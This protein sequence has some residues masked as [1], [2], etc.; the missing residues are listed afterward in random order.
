MV[1]LEGSSEIRDSRVVGPVQCP[2]HGIKDGYGDQQVACSPIDANTH[3]GLDVPIVVEY[4]FLSEQV[5]RRERGETIL[6]GHLVDRSA[7]S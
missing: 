6:N 3:E 2:R 7:S 5:S 1:V 4:V